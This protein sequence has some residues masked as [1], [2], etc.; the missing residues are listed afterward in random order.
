M[1]FLESLKM[2]SV[3][4]FARESVGGQ[5]LKDGGITSQAGESLLGGYHLFLVYVLFLRRCGLLFLKS[6]GEGNDN[7][8]QYSCLE[9]S[10]DRGAWRAIVYAVAKSQTQLSNT[11]SLGQSTQLNWALFPHL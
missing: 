10:M 4:C 6:S 7:P 8:L 9:D 3:I 11:F 5:K 1:Q 2:Q